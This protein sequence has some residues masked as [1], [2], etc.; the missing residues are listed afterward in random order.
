MVG[1]REQNLY[2]WLDW[3][4]DDLLPFSFVER[5]RVR[6]FCNLKPIS[7]ES[8]MAAMAKVCSV[9]EQKIK[10]MLPDMFHLM[11]DGWSAGG[12]PLHCY[13]RNLPSRQR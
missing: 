12:D 8:F 5:P 2:S 9:L 6:K 3:V 4:I 11:F 1:Q 7:V 13:D 10:S